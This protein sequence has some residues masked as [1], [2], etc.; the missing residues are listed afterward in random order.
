[1]GGQEWIACAQ[2]GKFEQFGVIRRAL[3][4]IAQDEKAQARGGVSEEEGRPGHCFSSDE[5]DA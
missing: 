2:G 1:L 4:Q 5:S 3:K